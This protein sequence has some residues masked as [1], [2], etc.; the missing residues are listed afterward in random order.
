MGFRRL[1]INVRSLSI[2]A[3]EMNNATHRVAEEAARITA[4]RVSTSARLDF[5]PRHFG[6]HMM[7]V[8]SR[9]Y[10]QLREL[11]PAYV[12]GY[13]HYVNL[14]NDGCYLSPE[15]ETFLIDQ[16]SNYFQG[17]V[18]ADAAGIIVTLYVLSELSFKYP[19][20]P[21]FADHFHQLRDFAAEH[22]E[23]ALIFAAID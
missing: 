17:T 9:I 15:G 5:L 16:P 19:Q 18:S 13:W 11:A 4:S 21:P 2:G 14:S 22:A 20:E 3:I 7:Q 12:G 10:E 8:E 6:R 23:A 1:C